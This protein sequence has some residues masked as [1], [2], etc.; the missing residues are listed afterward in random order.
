M[1]FSLTNV[2]LPSNWA[3]QGL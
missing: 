3:W 1:Q 2:I